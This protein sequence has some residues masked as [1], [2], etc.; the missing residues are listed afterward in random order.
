MRA[1]YQATWDSVRTHKVPD[2]YSDAKLGVFVHWGLYSVPGWAPSVPDIQEL[3]VRR[4]PKQMLRENPYAE[5][6]LNTMQIEGSSTQR[7]H[8][9]VYGDDFPYDNFVRNFDDAS[10]SANLNA[11][12]ELCDRAGARYVVLTTKHSDGFALWPSSVPHRVKGAYHAKRDLVG[13]LSDAVRA[14]GMRMG[15][16]YSG[17]Y[18]WS[19]NGVVLK[20]LATAVLAAPQDRGYLDFV[21]AQVRELIDRYHPSVLW[22][23]ISWPRGGNLA[24][25]FAYYY[26]AVDDG[27]INDRWAEQGPRN[28]LTV[29]FVHV[30]GGLV[31]ALWRV[32]PDSRKRLTFPSSKHY[33]FHTPEYAVV[34]SSSGRKWELCRGVG[35]SFG[36]NFHEQPEDIVSSTDLIRL[37]CDIVSKNGNLLIGVGPRANG[38]IPELQQAPL[39]GL[40]EWLRV[41]GAAI[42]GSRPWDVSESSTSGGTPLRFTEGGGADDGN[43][44]V[45]AMVLGEEPSRQVS[46]P[47]VDVANVQRVRLLGVDEPLEIST[48]DGTLTVTLPERFTM[49]AVTT[50]ALGSGVRAKPTSRP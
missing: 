44:V 45:F 15:L 31:Q 48:R 35:H 26:N 4:G 37:F 8:L 43:R 50:L 7:R 42:Y 12:A 47:V 3:L 29:A 27:V 21:T 30:L 36:A 5:W 18:D 33:D 11:V 28:T 16:Y 23:D 49:S 39:L 2:W 13:D 6:Y 17:G 40:G 1:M 34:R 20:N 25:L 22:N 24:E 46:L 19:Y 9:E 14:R 38:T 10:S 32:I 41:N